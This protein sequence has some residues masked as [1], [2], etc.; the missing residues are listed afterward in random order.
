MKL[1]EVA[2]D[3]ARVFER[4]RIQASSSTITFS[5]N[6][7]VF[8]FD[9]CSQLPFMGFIVGTRPL[10][11]AGCGL[12]SDSVVIIMSIHMGRGPGLFYEERR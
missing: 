4:K 11:L 9:T 7:F 2:E 5:I 10:L 8:S 3:T 6:K 12:L 1:N